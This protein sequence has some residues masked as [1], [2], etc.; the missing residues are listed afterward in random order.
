MT[1]LTPESRGAALAARLKAIAENP[2]RRNYLDSGVW[3]ELAKTH[4]IRL[5]QWHRPPTPR[6]LK[7]WHETLEKVRFLAI[8]EGKRP[9]A[10]DAFVDVYGCSP[11]KL[12]KLNPTMP[13]RAFIGQALERCR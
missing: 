6:K 8:P 4:G 11:A 1:P 12:I 3:D 13:L 7:R 10:P 5:P 2:F 9:D